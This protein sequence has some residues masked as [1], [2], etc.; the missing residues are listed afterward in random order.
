MA[1]LVHGPVDPDPEARV[2]YDRVQEAGTGLR[3]MPEGLIA[4]IAIETD[5]GFQVMGVWD[6]REAE[7][8]AHTSKR[9]KEL[10]A[11]LG[12]GPLEVSPP[13]HVHNIR[14]REFNLRAGASPSLAGWEWQTHRTHPLL[15]HIALSVADLDACVAW[16]Q[17][18]LGCLG[19]H[20][21]RRLDPVT[22]GSGL[23]MVMMKAGGVVIEL[24]EK[25]GAA[26]N[27]KAFAPLGESGDI[28]GY[29]HAGFAVD[30]AEAVHALLRENGVTV[31]DD[32]PDTG[33][34]PVLRYFW[35]L[36]GN[37]VQLSSNWEGAAG[38]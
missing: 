20:E 15:H 5:D 32:Y 19:F 38:Q 10:R 14:T 3:I 31:S 35:D 36:E 8:A 13:K 24:L 11:R 21:Y 9:V 4:H 16:Y 27:P 17:D 22:P 6:S 30:D 37:L 34:S 33:G 2:K 26:P 28:R 25:P 12:L 29:T 1:I 23:R 18:K 7:R